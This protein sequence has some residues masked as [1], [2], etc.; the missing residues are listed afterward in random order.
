MSSITTNHNFQ[1]EYALEEFIWAHLEAIFNIKPL[2]RQVMLN[3][4]I[5]DILGTDENHQL[6]IIELKN[7]EDRYV[8]PQLTRYYNYALSE[9]PFSKNVDY[10]KPIRLLAIAP[11][12]HEHSLIDRTYSHLCFELLTFQITSDQHGFHFQLHNLDTDE[13]TTIDI[14]EPFHQFLYQDSQSQSKRPQLSKP[15]KSLTR[16]L[17]NL[18]S[19]K[20]DEIMTLREEILSFDDR[21]IEVGRTTVTEYGLQKGETGI[22]K[23]KC[24]AEIKPE[25]PGIYYPCL[26]AI[27]PYAKREFGAPGHAYKK[28]PVIGLSWALIWSRH[29]HSEIYFYLGNR[30]TS[31]YSFSYTLEQYQQMLYKLT[32]QNKKLETVSDLLKLGLE[33]WRQQVAR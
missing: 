10:E 24:C 7:E 14:P 11:S 30:R 15:P 2:A 5:C 26:R 9:K 1:N 21:I 4:Q 18:S 16:L 31:R 12:F 6:V 13:M 22:Y 3:R 20:R 33:A 8:L 23:T 28:I 25:L 17:E 27:L 19:E 29:H 32:G